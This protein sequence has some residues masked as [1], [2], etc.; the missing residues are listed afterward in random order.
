[1]SFLENINLKSKMIFFGGAIAAIVL[2]MGATTLYMVTQKQAVIERNLTQTQDMISDTMALF[3]AVK[4][5]NF[6]V[7][8]VQQ[9]LTD[10]SATRGK[11]GLN[12]GFERAAEFALKFDVDIA[13]A[14]EYSEK[15]H[16]VNLSNTLKE[17]KVN[18]TAY[19]ETGKKMAKSY[20]EYGPSEGNKMMGMFDETAEQ[21]S[22][23]VATMVKIAERQ[24]QLEKEKITETVSLIHQSL[25]E[26]S[27]LSIIGS[28]IVL[29]VCTAL[30]F[31]IQNMVAVPLTRLNGLMLELANGNDDI[32]LPN[33]NRGDE[34]GMMSDNLRIF[35]DK[36]IENKR[37][38]KE[39]EE[40][41]IARQ[42]REE[43]RQ[44][45]KQ[46]AEQKQLETE[47]RHEQEIE[48]QFQLE[49]EAMAKRFED[50]ISDVLQGVASAATEL[51]ATSES[52]N[53]AANNM[54]QESSSAATATTRAGENVQLV[55]SASEEM[56]ASVKEISNQIAHSSDA[57]RNALASVDN[58]SNRVTQM[59]NSSEKI[60][61]IIELINDIAEQTNLL[62]LNATIEAARAGEAGKGF[63]VVASEVKS[64]ASQTA[65]ATE[66]IRKQIT[67]MQETTDDT[68][69]AV[70]EISLTIRELDEIS[71]SITSSMKEQAAAM[72]EISRNSLEAATGAETA[73]ANVTTVSYLAEETGNAASDVLNASKELS[74]QAS[75]LKVAVDGFL[76]E[77]RAG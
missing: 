70:Q 68:V 60:N 72:Q 27:S 11:D 10:I 74:T 51:N 12:D 5:I 54:K 13:R 29:V 41:R 55:A 32:E 77:I 21:I 64:L 17:M 76:S 16:L 42:E 18:F 30:V 25:G 31:L 22:A 69:S 33:L 34:I 59:V 61:E 66:E 37:L 58:A 2:I 3:R 49:R 20:I 48:K 56:T 62:A 67:N 63:A 38:A 40:A 9:W 57:S 45:E 24:V 46:I 43:Q 28:L 71:S 44:R 52:M 26:L 75:T 73:G 14:L 36:S 65:S 39:A 15:M 23:N 1:M 50:Q 53:Q 4:D 6:D 7:V 47:R 8:Q 35:Q 19:Y